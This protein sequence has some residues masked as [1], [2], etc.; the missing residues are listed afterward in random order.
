MDAHKVKRPADLI[1]FTNQVPR[2][3]YG[4]VVGHSAE[5]G[6]HFA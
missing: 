4:Q 1:S 6:S 3:P 2:I 5:L